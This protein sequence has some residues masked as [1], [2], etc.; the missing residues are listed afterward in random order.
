MEKK[1][2]RKTGEERKMNYSKIREQIE[3]EIRED[4]EIKLVEGAQKM[5]GDL[6]IEMFK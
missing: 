4:K 5:I 1:K 6:S 2:R 3:R